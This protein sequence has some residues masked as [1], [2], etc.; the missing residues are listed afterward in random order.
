MVKSGAA[1]LIVFTFRRVRASTSTDSFQT[2]DPGRARVHRPSEAAPD[3]TSG[4]ADTDHA[5]A[6]PY[7]RLT[8]ERLGSIILPVAY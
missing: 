7:L 2:C 6:R 4:R 8:A 5:G 1:P 3:M